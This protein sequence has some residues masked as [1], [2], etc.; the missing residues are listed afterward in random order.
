MASRSKKAN[1]KQ[2]GVRVVCIALAGL[3]LL[4]VVLSVLWQW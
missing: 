1:A 4:S 2:L 3:M